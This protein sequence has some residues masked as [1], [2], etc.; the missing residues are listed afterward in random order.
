MSTKSL[1][2]ELKELP[3]LKE[4]E[5]KGVDTTPQ[6]R[7]LRHCDVH[8][9]ETGHWLRGTPP[10]EDLICNLCHPDPRELL[11]LA[12]A[13]ECQPERL[14]DPEASPRKPSEPIHVPTAKEL[15]LPA[16]GS[17]FALSR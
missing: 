16:D 6:T 1:T 12:R 15:G 13:K 3:E 7:V 9:R 5:V 11:A 8:R 4:P 14:S 17:D 10:C 2:L